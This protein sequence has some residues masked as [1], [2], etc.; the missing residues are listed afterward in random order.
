[1]EQIMQYIPYLIPVVILQ[2]AL[3]II[4]LVHVFRHDHY[5]HGSRVLWVIIVV[6][7]NIIGP[8]L[9]FVIGR[10]DD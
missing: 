2:F 3:M 5:K 6:L 9:Y 10:S 7:I 4:A 1:M 8:I